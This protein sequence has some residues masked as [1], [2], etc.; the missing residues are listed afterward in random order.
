MAKSENSIELL[1]RK[2]LL[3]RQRTP[4]AA[5]GTWPCSFP[6]LYSAA[7]HPGA[8]ALICDCEHLCFI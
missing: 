4:G 7:Q 5:L 3:W 6:G 2:E 8:I 1:I